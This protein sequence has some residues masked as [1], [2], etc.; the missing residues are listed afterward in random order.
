EIPLLACIISIVYS[1]DVMTTGRPYKEPMSKKEAL[2]E[3]NRCAGS[4]FD[5]ELVKIFMDMMKTS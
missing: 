1:Y 3:L 5:P 4:Q 2:E